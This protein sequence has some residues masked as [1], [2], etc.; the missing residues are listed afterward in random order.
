VKRNVRRVVAVGV[1][2]VFLAGAGSALA[3]VTGSGATFPRIAYENWCRDS[4]ICSY[5]AKGSG[6]GINDFINGVVDF[7]A[8]DATLTPQQFSDLASKRGG[9]TP[10]YFPT[11]LGAVTVP[12]NVG[13]VSGNAVKLDGKVV[14]DI[15]DGAVKSW[16][17]A[18]IRATNPKVALPA[19]PITVC[20]RAD[21]SGTTFNFSRYLTKVNPGFRS[22][23]SFGQTVPWSAPNVIKSPGNAGVAS[24]VK[25]NQ[26][27]VGYVDLGDAL[28]AGLAGN[29]TSIG[30]TQ[31]VRKGKKK[32]RKTV[33]IRP[34]IASIQAAGQLKRLKP[35]LTIDFSASPNPGAYPIAITT[36][37]LA[38]SD[39]AAAGKSGSLADVKSFLNYAYANAAQSKLSSLGFAPLP[40]NVLAAAKK[41]LTKLK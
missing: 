30:K 2:G 9:V 31:V 27:S 32:V 3:A 35:D 26:N 10:L 6:G 29:I 37:I 36:W 39:Y 5:T 38:Y 8:S 16:N 17:D 20:V 34:T 12:V 13:G 23:V 11:L 18:K 25:N 14:G 4:G 15:F 19:A 21:G 1:S 40:T 41:Q 24:C 28:N 7:A 22:Q 33:F